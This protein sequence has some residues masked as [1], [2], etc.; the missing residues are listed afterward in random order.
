MENPLREEKHKMY[1]VA[2]DIG[3]LECG[4]GS[5]V[6]GIFTTEKK[7]DEVCENH[8][9]RQGLKWHGQHSFKTFCVKQIDIVEYVKYK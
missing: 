8:A 5:N 1:Y 3:C 9:V 4:E 7:A 2:V 6:L